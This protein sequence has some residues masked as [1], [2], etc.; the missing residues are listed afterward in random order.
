M[1]AP[2]TDPPAM[3]RRLFSSCFQKRPERLPSKSPHIEG[4]TETDG[5]FV[6][7]Q[8]LQISPTPRS[9]RD[10]TQL[11][12][13]AEATED[14][15]MPKAAKAKSATKPSSRKPY[16]NAAPSAGSDPKSVFV[17]AHSFSYTKSET[18]ADLVASHSYYTLNGKSDNTYRKSKTKSASNVSKTRG[19]AKDEI[20]GL[21][22]SLNAMFDELLSGTS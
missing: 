8:P 10:Q 2:D 13:E 17:F 6:T 5:S 16:E 7:L 19:S 21:E 12:K 3:L 22:K 1:A 4:A 11:S 15:T 20:D 14:Q 18:G 9:A